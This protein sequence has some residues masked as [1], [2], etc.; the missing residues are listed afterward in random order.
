MVRYEGAGDKNPKDS[1]QTVQ[2][3]RNITY[4]EVTKEILEVGKY[5]T[6]WKP[7]RTQQFLYQ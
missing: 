7:D 5:T 2:W 4:D 3:N 6:D 1:I